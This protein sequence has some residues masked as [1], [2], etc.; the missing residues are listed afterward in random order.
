M[1]RHIISSLLVAVIAFGACVKEEIPET[2]KADLTGF[3]A[4]YNEDGTVTITAGF[5]SRFD[6]EDTKTHVSGGSKVYWSTGDNAIYVFDTDDNKYQFTSSETGAQATRKFTGSLSSGAQIKYI[7]WTGRNKSQTDA[8][9]IVTT[10]GGTMYSEDMTQGNGGSVIEWDTKA[11]GTLTSEYISGNTLEVVNPQNINNTNSFAGNAN[12]TIMKKGDAAMRNVFGY[13][14]FTVPEGSDGA[15]AIKSIAFTADQALAGKIQIEYSG[16]DP[17]VYLDPNG[18]KTLTVNMR[19][20]GSKYE[21]GTLFAILAPGTYTNLK[22]TVTPFSNGATTQNAATGTPFVL[23]STK[24]VT[25]KRG[26]YADL[27][28]L[29]ASKPDPN[30]VFGQIAQLI[31]K[32]TS[33]GGLC[34]DGNYL[35]V[36]TGGKIH[37]YEIKNPM[38]PQLKSSVKIFG[39]PRQITAC[40]GYLYVSARETGVWVYSLTKPYQPSLVKR[41]DCVELATG[42]DAAGD[43][44]F[45][46][47]RQNG[48]EFVDIRTPSSPAHIRL[49]DTD[50]S[51]SVFYCNGYLYSGEW[52]SG[53]ITIFDARD[54]DNI[55][56]LKTIDLQGYGD[57]LWITGNRLYASTGHHHR[58]HAAKTQDGDGHGVEIWDISDPENPSFI[59]RTEFDIFY[60]SGI[61]YWMPRPSGDGKTL[62]CGDV[63]N[64][65]YV[66]DIQ[67]ESSPKIIEHY[68]LSS[69]SAVTSVALGNGVVYLATSKDGLLVMKCS[70]ALPAPATAGRCPPKPGHVITIPRLHPDL[71]HG[72]RTREAPCTAWPHGEATSSS[73]A[74]TPAFPLSHYPGRAAGGA[75]T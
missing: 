8:T 75:P 28:R 18:N 41:Y 35:Y 71:L 20:N 26:K 11:T 47:Q 4:V 25:I 39:T 38:S 49:I 7:I 67:N 59:S 74:A 51:Q 16:D 10:S 53:K 19:W 29:P 34:V 55:K 42:I 12:I 70:R 48:V 68:T 52:S 6:D 27:G 13:I 15:S 72:S 1:N 23:S 69:G 60:Q 65:L 31:P 54:L 14:R 57:G 37:T 62:F 61:D 30:A 2:V 40:N 17:V 3:P 63:F 32:S 46:G 43:C 9:Q 58:N 45:V 21:A 64:G 36:G 50:E 22:M 56:K 73:A 24:S 33:V 66:V 44:M 5:E